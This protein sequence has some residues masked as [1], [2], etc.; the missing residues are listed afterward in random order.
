MNCFKNKTYKNLMSSFGRFIDP[1]HP[2]HF[3][4]IDIEN[5]F[6][7]DIIKKSFFT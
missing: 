6:K 1:E 2:Y 4:D 5:L 7:S 3:I